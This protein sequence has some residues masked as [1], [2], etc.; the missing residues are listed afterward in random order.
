MTMTELE[1]RVEVPF[2]MDL[3]TLADLGGEDM[4]DP[5]TLVPHIE[6]IVSAVSERRYEKPKAWSSIY[7]EITDPKRPRPVELSSF[8]VSLTS[9]LMEDLVE[10]AY[11]INRTPE[12]LL[13]AAAISASVELSGANAA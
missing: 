12:S 11:H 6:S 9:R 7:I 13:F 2:K 4:F 3:C 5:N 1:P 10:A 8:T